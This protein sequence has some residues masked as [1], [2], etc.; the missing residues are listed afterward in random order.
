MEQQACEPIHWGLTNASEGSSADS[1]EF[2]G[3]FVADMYVE[4][5]SLGDGMQGEV[6][7]SADP[8]EALHAQAKHC[9]R[10]EVRPEGGG[11]GLLLDSSAGDR[12]HR[13]YAASCQS[14]TFITFDRV[15]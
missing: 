8:C 5:Y 1:R 2:I 12:R 3:E 4:I 10:P 7:K 9:C 15:Q 6:C 14:T 11:Q 13:V